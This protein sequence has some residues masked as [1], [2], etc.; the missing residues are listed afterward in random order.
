MGNSQYPA[1]L[2]ETLARPRVHQQVTSPF[3]GSGQWMQQGM[4]G[5]RRGGGGWRSDYSW[6]LS[7]LE[8]CPIWVKGWS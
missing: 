8:L 2:S 6:L 7:L 3:Q 5:L 1:P 4:R